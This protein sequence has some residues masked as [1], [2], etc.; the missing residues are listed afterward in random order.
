MTMM[1]TIM[2]VVGVDGFDVFCVYYASC[3]RTMSTSV[4][5]SDDG[6]DDGDFFVGS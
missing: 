2:Y 4:L 1:T 3:C 5:L 6:V